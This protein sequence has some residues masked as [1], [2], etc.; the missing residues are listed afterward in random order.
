MCVGSQSI[1]GVNGENYN[2]AKALNI[3]N[4]VAYRD[5]L[6]KAGLLTRDSRVVERKKA[7]LIKARKGQVFK[8][9]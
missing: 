2:I 5:A 1:K 4:A 9:R 7:G 6:K 3:L 8:R